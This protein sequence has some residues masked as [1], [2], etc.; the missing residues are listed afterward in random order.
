[1]GL[2]IFLLA[3]LV[4]CGANRGTG[5][6]EDTGI[7]KTPFETAVP[8]AD[9]GVQE[10]I[11]RYD[12]D[13]SLLFQI[14]GNFT[15]S[16][17]KEILAF[18]HDKHRIFIDND[19]VQHFDIDDVYC[20]ILDNAGADILRVYEIP[21]YLSGEFDSIFNLDDSLIELLGED[22][23]WLGKRLGVTGDFNNNGINELY[24]Y[25]LTGV[26]F[27]PKFYEFDGTRFKQIFE[28]TPKTTGL[29]LDHVDMENKILGFREGSGIFFQWD[30]NEKMYIKGIMII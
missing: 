4:G 21:D 12:S 17:N 18:Y 23:I 13:W 2:L 26:G 9:E 28:H 1:M 27:Y 3:I 10:K 29:E 24:L 22:I 16:G 20:F 30:E 5:T 6:V 14:E 19:G 7:E 8:K 11:E 15:N 25:Q